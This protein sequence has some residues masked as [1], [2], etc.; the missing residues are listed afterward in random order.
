MNPLGTHMSEDRGAAGETLIQGREDNPGTQRVLIVMAWWTIERAVAELHGTLVRDTGK[1][2][3]VQGQVFLWVW[4]TPGS[5][6]LSGTG[7]VSQGIRMTS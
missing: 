5:M 6:T 4:G 3:G 2:P 7:E 1:V